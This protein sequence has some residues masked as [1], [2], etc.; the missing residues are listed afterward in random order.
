MDNSKQSYSE[1]YQ[2]K[3]ATVP[4][5]PALKRI[6][7]MSLIAKDLGGNNNGQW[8]SALSP[9]LR[10]PESTRDVTRCL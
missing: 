6:A 3:L 1:K 4:K 9:N 5:I 2:A 8:L 7:L 10:N